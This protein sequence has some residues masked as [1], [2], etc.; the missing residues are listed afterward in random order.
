MTRI[1]VALI[2]LL[3]FPFIVGCACR[4]HDQRSDKRVSPN[5]AVT[6]SEAAFDLPPIQRVDQRAGQPVKPFATY[7]QCQIELAYSVDAGTG[8]PVV[9]DRYRA[10]IESCISSA[11]KEKVNVLILPELSLAFREA[12]RNALLERLKATAQGQ[13]MVILAGSYYDANRQSRL[14]VIGPGWE[15]LGYKLKPSR[16]EASPRYGFGMEE[17][18]GLLL[19]ETIY[20]R[21]MPLTCVDLLSDT[22]QYS[23]RNLATRG[24]VDVVANLN[25]NPA[26]WEFLIEANGIARRHPVVVSITN[27]SGSPDPKRK[28][29][30]LQKG[31]NGYCFGNSALFASLRERESDCPN[32]AQAV[33]DLVAPAFKTGA[34][35]SLPYDTLVATVPPFQEALLIYDVNLRMAREPASTNAPDQGYPVVR[36]VRRVLLSEP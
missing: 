33:T 8:L 34:A 22:A 10:K 5:P 36:N 15:E 27:V 2:A 7:G 3:I 16:F 4:N 30:C 32:C 25:F 26:A 23:V 35:R 19:L 12:T 17:G 20:G 9:D 21:I 6:L 13:G 18:K 1:K 29:E 28:A 24:Q 31:D 14:P 11:V